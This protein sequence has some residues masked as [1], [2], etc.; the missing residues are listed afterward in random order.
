ML[1]WMMMFTMIL[2]GGH[3]GCGSGKRYGTDRRDR[4]KPGVWT[5]AGGFG[6]DIY[7]SRSR[8]TNT[9]GQNER[10]SNE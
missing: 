4:I 8:V 9:T 1:G 2:L 7:T 3:R 6:S 10:V 5:S